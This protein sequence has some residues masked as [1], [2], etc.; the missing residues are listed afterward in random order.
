VA[1]LGILRD[2]LLA[3][4]VD[5]MTSGLVKRD[6]LARQLRT[7]SMAK[8]E[9]FINEYRDGPAGLQK[10]CEETGLALRTVEAIVRERVGMPAHAYL[11]R[12]RLAFAREA[13][14]KPNDGATVTNIA[15]HFGFMHLGRFSGFY[16]QVYGELPSMTFR[17]VL[18]RNAD[19]D[20]KKQA[21]RFRCSSTRG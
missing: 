12:R 13:L 14:L 11:A 19:E 3:A 9:R 17:R 21:P 5:M 7:V 15:M 2:E 20:D 8:I 6:H 4:V 16:R 18:G 1:G 10:L